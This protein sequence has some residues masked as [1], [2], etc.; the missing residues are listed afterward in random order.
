M[1]NIKNLLSYDEFLNEAKVNRDTKISDVSGSDLEGFLKKKFKTG[2]RGSYDFETD[3]NSVKMF[4]DLNT[5]KGYVK[6]SGDITV[7]LD[8]AKLFG[9]GGFGIVH[10]GFESYDDLDFIVELIKEYITKQK[11]SITG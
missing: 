6:N 10:S 3:G 9:S 2:S 7:D 1:K 11:K 8:K 4:F 5:K